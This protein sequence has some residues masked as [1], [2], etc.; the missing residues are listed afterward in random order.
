MKCSLSEHQKIRNSL[1][2]LSGLFG[3]VFLVYLVYLV[4]LVCLIFWYSDISPDRDLPT[5]MLI[6]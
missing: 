6:S 2:G 5:D 1:S 3:L 4:L